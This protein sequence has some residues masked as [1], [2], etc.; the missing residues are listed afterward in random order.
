MRYIVSVITV[1]GAHTVASCSD[2]CAETDNR[3]EGNVAHVCRTTCDEWHT[4]CKPK[5]TSEDCAASGTECAVGRDGFG[6][7]RGLCAE[8][9]K[10]AC[11]EGEASKCS[12]DGK[13]V[14]VCAFG[15]WQRGQSCTPELPSCKVTEGQ[16]RCMTSDG[17]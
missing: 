10:T 6:D 11:R 2:R 9:P 14:L 5:R 3:C 8:A 4:D 17:R 16:A 7:A 1:L 15:F 13:Q 12:A